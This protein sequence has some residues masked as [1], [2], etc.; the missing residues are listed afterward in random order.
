MAFIEEI[1]PL[2]VLTES[3]PERMV[4]RFRGRVW[5]W[6]LLLV[7]AG[8]VLACAWFLVVGSPW[9]GSFAL[10]GAFG[11]V[12][13]YSSFYSF[14][15]DQFLVADGVTRSLRFHKKNLYGSDG[16]EVPGDRFG[17]IKVRR[18]RASQ[19]RAMNWSIVLAGADGREVFI[20]EN[21]FGSLDRDRAVALATRVGE[22]TGI[23]VDTGS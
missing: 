7:G 6:I 12:L 2:M 23:S 1:P 16:W 22:L 4:F 5:G 11:V 3:S 10:L 8:V 13:L 17:V 15:A 20:G 19:G 14:T 21:E 18:A 9:T